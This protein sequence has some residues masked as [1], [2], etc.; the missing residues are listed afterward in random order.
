MSVV[1]CR[2]LDN[3]Y[4]IASDSITVRGYTQTKTNT[5]FSKL[6]E[7]NDMVFGGVGYAEE[8]A[9]LN[10]FAKTHLIAAATEEAILDFISE[11][12]SWKNGKTGFCPGSEGY[13]HL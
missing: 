10:V 1:A 9:L 6:F 4:E 3:G 5:S 8:S 2:I 11:F 12:S 13:G 7:V